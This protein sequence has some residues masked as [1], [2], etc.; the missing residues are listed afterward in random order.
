MQN[1]SQAYYAPSST[2]F[3]PSSVV[4]RRTF[5]NTPKVHH[6]DHHQYEA[7]HHE[8]A[9]RSSSSSNLYNPPVYSSPSS[10]IMNQ[11]QVMPPQPTNSNSYPNSGMVQQQQSGV[12]LPPLSALFQ[13]PDH[14]SVIH[15][16]TTFSTEN[17][18]YQQNPPFPSQPI[19]TIQSH[20]S[21]QESCNASPISYH[22]QTDQN[23]AFANTTGSPES[24]FVNH[25]K[26]FQSY[27]QNVAREERRKIVRVSP[28][29]QTDIL[30]KVLKYKHLNITPDLLNNSPYNIISAEVLENGR[31][32]NAYVLIRKKNHVHK[33][34]FL[35]PN[36]NI[37]LE[38]YSFNVVILG[39]INSQNK[40]N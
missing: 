23:Q 36:G 37:R 13:T 7:Y 18:H 6:T 14:H 4:P 9:V 5:P 20:R 35:V 8:T 38:D 15:S 25:K 16:N 19:R 1:T 28:N 31:V 29:Q 30:L 2:H 34:K 17:S 10:V 39:P 12:I 33:S 21:P 40:H 3:V 24:T 26:I 11:Q 27:V 22:T 32:M